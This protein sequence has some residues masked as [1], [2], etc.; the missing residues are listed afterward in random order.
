MKV[1][2]PHNQKNGE[3]SDKDR[4]DDAVGRTPTSEQFTNHTDQGC[5]ND[6]NEHL[7]E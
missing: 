7:R 3:E 4:T 1:E 2:D 6:P 5:N